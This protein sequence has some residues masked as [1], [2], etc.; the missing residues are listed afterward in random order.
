MK[1]NASSLLY[2]CT[3]LAL[4]LPLFVLAD[5]IKY[6][7]ENNNTHFVDSV[8]KVPEQFRAKIEQLTAQKIS[9]V[10]AATY[11]PLPK[12]ATLG[13]NAST[14]EVLVATWC[15]YCTALENFLVE[16]KIKYTK[17][18]IEHDAE[19][20]AQYDKLGRGGVPITLIGSKVIRGYDPSEILSTIKSNRS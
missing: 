20:R 6:T 18:D 11:A 4:S 15:S 17:L 5:V 14:V 10:T 16:N 3:L 9:R 8:E 13:K 12:S 1:L 2:I 19:G 7:D